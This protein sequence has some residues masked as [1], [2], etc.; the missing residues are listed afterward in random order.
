M[1]YLNRN[2]I[3]PYVEF[4]TPS[5][6]EAREIGRVDH[7]ISMQ[8][9]QFSLGNIISH[10]EAEEVS[11]DSVILNPGD[12]PEVYGTVKAQFKTHE[13]GIV[14]RGLLDFK[15][16][17]PSLNKVVSQE[18]FASEFRWTT[19]WATFTG[20]ERALYDDQKKLLNRKEIPLPNPQFMF[21]QF[22]APLYDQVVKKLRTYYSDY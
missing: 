15:I 12:D 19:T 2:T 1:E 5:E 14:G 21:E 22:A 4:Y 6:V 18:K 11:R 16:I 20:D 9:D 13:K 3:N 7:R 10:T 17:D 8:F